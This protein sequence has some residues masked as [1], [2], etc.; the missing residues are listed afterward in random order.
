MALG[1]FV[2]SYTFRQWLPNRVFAAKASCSLDIR[3]R[4]ASRDWVKLVLD[5]QHMQGELLVVPISQA[6]RSPLVAKRH[7]TKTAKRFSELLS[8]ANTFVGAV[9]TYMILQGPDPV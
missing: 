6:R 1:K 5:V 7:L 2:Y 4:S 8:F 9:L 3:A